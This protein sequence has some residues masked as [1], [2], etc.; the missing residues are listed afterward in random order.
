[1][2]EKLRSTDAVDL[3]IDKHMITSLYRLGYNAISMT[4]VSNS[5]SSIGY[6]IFWLFKGADDTFS[7]LC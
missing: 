3:G 5:F 7:T 2:S 6:I 1:M 4:L